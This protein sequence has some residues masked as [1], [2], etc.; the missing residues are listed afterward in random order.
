MKSIFFQL[1][2][3]V[4]SLVHNPLTA[5]VNNP[6]DSLYTEW[7]TT[8]QQ[9][10][11]TFFHNI[12]LI[13]SIAKYDDD[14]VV[15][16]DIL[17]SLK[18][19]DKGFKGYTNANYCYQLGY[20]YFYS[21]DFESSLYYY[22]NAQD[23]Y[24]KLGD[25]LAGSN[26]LLEK[27]NN[28][29]KLRDF[30]NAFNVIL[31]T[32]A[33]FEKTGDPLLLTKSYNLLG[34]A[35]YKQGHYDIAIP[36]YEKSI[37]LAIANGFHEWVLD[38]Y[39]G[40]GSSYRKGGHINKALDSYNSALN[41]SKE[42]DYIKSEELDFIY[43][44]IGNCF[45]DMGDYPKALEYYSNALKGRKKANEKELD[46]PVS[47]LITLS[48][49][50]EVYLKLSDLKKSKKYYYQ[51]RDVANKSKLV[52]WILITEMDVANV[53][54]EDENYI[55]AEKSFSNA[56]K[57]AKER[58]DK[59]TEILALLSLAR[60]SEL[61]GKYNLTIH[62]LNQGFEACDKSYVN[63][64]CLELLSLSSEIYLKRGDYDQVINYAE[65]GIK[66][67][68]K[69]G[70]L[71][72]KAD[73]LKN[74]S[75]A[76]IEKKKYKEAISILKQ[77]YEIRE[78][79]F[80]KQAYQE[81]GK[82][83]VRLEM[84][85]FKKDKEFEVKNLTSKNEIQ[86][87][88]LVQ[89]KNVIKSVIIGLILISLFSVSL[90]RL[91]QFK[92]K[93]VLQLEGA[94]KLLNDS[95]LEKLQLIDKLKVKEKELQMELKN[96]LLMILS[97]KK[98]IN[99]MEDSINKLGIEHKEKQL[100]LRLLESY[101][102]KEIIEQIENQYL[103]A[104]N[105]FVQAL[106]LKHPNLSLRNVK[107]CILIKLGLSVKEVAQIFYISTSSAKVAKSRLKHKLD[108]DL[109]INLYNYLNTIDSQYASSE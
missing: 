74:L 25:Y 73:L 16:Q 23:I 68:D 34:D 54:M 100:I 49:I 32:L 76:F 35:I 19:D 86:N 17:R 61:T 28:Y 57:V 29:Y 48:N 10:Q 43:I 31:D 51:A 95:N 30:E 46:S 45:L 105:R 66:S 56:L 102:N 89:Q 27:V 13:K 26:C 78:S 72:Y 98:M 77:E 55:E 62:Y 96:K 94:N 103:E 71:A 85:K 79:I 53:E 63:Q 104:N 91:Y 101:S 106:T 90:F 9:Y 67:I 39:R 47:L 81:L 107:F 3:V 97:G 109:K 80:D 5:Q 12:D 18:E 84:E 8:T 6:L 83:E 50:A 33:Y 59:P 44:N 92:R 60:V 7:K 87:L 2:L 40:K 15:L 36:Y 42:N 69:S 99:K 88:K 14:K 93:S 108:Y 41:Y 52:S 22:S 65:K 37:E 38:A 70:S 82:F 75:A 24:N 20:Y 4:L 64:H 11:Q 58:K 1:G 21:K